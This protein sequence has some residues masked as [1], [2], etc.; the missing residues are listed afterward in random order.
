MKIPIDGIQAFVCVA[1]VGSFNRAADKLS[2]TQTALTRRIQRLEAFV[3]TRLLDRT[4][5]ATALTQMGREF[6]P[7]A[8]RLV[9]DLTYG[10]DRLRNVSRHALGDV[11]VATVQSVAFHHLPRVMRIYARLY[12][13]NRVEFVERSGA[14]VTAAVLAGETDFGIHIQ[15]SEIAGLVEEPITTD[16]LVLVCNRNHPLANA[17]Q[18]PWKDL[19]DVD[20]VTLGG[21]S[22]NKKLIEAQLAAVGLEPRGRFVVES[23]PAAVALAAAGVA[24][25]IL[26]AT[27][28]AA[29]FASGLVEVP[30]VDPIVR[31]TISIVRRRGETLTPAAEA[32]LDIVRAE[33]KV[34]P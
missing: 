26:P 25:A 31:R 10:L 32:L 28:K 14:L 11:K 30:L 13:H 6:L 27:M 29:A 8:A 5:R 19:K 18:L 12:P 20:F 21:A 7:L 4:T 24:A 3:G 22:G 15:H 16:P 23:T 17:A 1:E 2:I 9:E 34:T 33:L